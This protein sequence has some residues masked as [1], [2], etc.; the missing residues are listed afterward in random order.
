MHGM[1]LLHEK[2]RNC[3]GMLLMNKNI[4]NILLCRCN[5]YQSSVSILQGRCLKL[6][7]VSLLL[8]YFRLCTVVWNRFCFQPS[9]AGF[10]SGVILYGTMI[11][12]GWV[13]MKYYAAFIRYT[14]WYRMLQYTC[15]LVIEKAMMPMI[16]QT[17]PQFRDSKMLSVTCHDENLLLVTVYIVLHLAACLTRTP[18]I[19]QV[20]CIIG[21]GLYPN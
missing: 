6:L 3:M 2:W 4:Y 1:G 10:Q 8:T 14:K 17:R 16:T 7:R 18:R 15:Q 20:E 12:H 19:N 11:T 21:R 9:V 13:V 5:L